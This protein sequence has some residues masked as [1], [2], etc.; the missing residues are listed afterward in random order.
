M[1]ISDAEWVNFI[2]KLK[3]L[4]DM[5]AEE[6]KQYAINS[7][8]FNEATQS[9]VV[10]EDLIQYAY[11]IATR[12]GEASASL[13]ALLYDEIAAAEGV[14]LPPAEVAPTASY[15]DV[16]Q[17]IYGSHEFS[18]TL[19]VLGAALS[20]LVKLAG[21]DTTVK[22]AIRDRAQI[23]FVPHGDTCAYCI[24]LASSGWRTATDAD[25]KGGH[26]A[27][28]HGNCDCTYAVRHRKESFV[29]SYDPDKYAKIYRDANGDTKEER[30]NSMRREFYAENAE[31]I[32][33]QKR[34]AYARE[35][36]L[37]SSSAEE[38]NVT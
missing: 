35:R 30:L 11:A 18:P 10:T 9:Y 12:Y 13:A 32:R 1:I 7:G 36:A 34:D 37:E 21:V 19:V 15:R 27:H 28:C 22:N 38:T 24:M 2:T 25:L 29:K 17:A 6:I 33:G 4:D 3:A 14:S 8:A 16:I 20:R 5:A 26:V 31:K 23:A